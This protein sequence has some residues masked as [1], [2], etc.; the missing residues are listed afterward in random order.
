MAKYNQVSKHSRFRADVTLLSNTHAQTTAVKTN[1]L[2]SS[3]LLR[4]LKKIVDVFTFVLF[5]MAS[6]SNN[7]LNSEAKERYLQ[8][9]TL[10]NI[11]TCPYLFPADAWKNYPTKWPSVEWPEVYEYLI[12]TPALVM[13]YGLKHGLCGLNP[14]NPYLIHI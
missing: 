3:F 1:S 6:Y 2:R 5:K 13:R 10:C 12:S 9:L 11:D 7:D 4:K 8:K 14:D